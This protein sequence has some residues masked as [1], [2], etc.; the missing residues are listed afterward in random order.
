MVDNLTSLVKFQA[1]KYHGAPPFT[2]MNNKSASRIFKNS[3]TFPNTSRYIRALAL[4]K[5]E[6]NI[7][8]FPRY[9]YNYTVA[10]LSKL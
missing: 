4:D 8:G 9:K 3:I 5:R 1:Y 6:E 10:V 7:Y 2:K